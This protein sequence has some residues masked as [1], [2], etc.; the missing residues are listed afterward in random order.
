MASPKRDIPHAKLGFFILVC[1][2]LGTPDNRDV[3]YKCMLIPTG[4]LVHAL[5]RCVP[6]S[7]SNA[8]AIF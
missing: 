4:Q 3:P 5:E 6:Y 7:S 8:E 1:Q 2:D